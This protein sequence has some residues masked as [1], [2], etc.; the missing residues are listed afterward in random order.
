MICFPL[1]RYTERQHTDSLVCAER[2]IYYEEKN[3]LLIMGPMAGIKKT[4]CHLSVKHVHYQPTEWKSY[5]ALFN[6]GLL[7]YEFA[8]MW[9]CYANRK[10][11]IIYN[12]YLKMVIFIS[13]HNPHEKFIN[14]W[15]GLS[16]WKMNPLTSIMVR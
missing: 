16:C 10:N 7:K 13:T 6:L 11:T 9:L 12:M 15:N 1:L 14:T 3:T 5:M 2:G 4:L 8:K